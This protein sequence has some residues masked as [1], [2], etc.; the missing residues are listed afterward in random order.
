M[1]TQCEEVGGTNG[2]TLNERIVAKSDQE[3][4][5][6]EVQKAVSRARAGY[7]TALEHSKVGDYNTNGKVERC[8]QD[9]KGLVRTLRSDLEAKIGRIGHQRIHF[10]AEILDD[11]FLD[12]A[13]ARVQV[14]NGQQGFYPLQPGFPDTDQQPR[15]EWN[16][17]FARIANGAQ[18]DLGILIWRSVVRH[19]LGTKP[20]RRAL[21][22]QS[23]LHPSRRS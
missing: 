1:R 23:H 16:F 4:A 6:V 17:R 19:A 13:I 15:G 7:G 9:F 18:A 10:G 14:A 21:Q 20:V 11:H 8:I 5:I 22:H 3:N 12:M 2:P